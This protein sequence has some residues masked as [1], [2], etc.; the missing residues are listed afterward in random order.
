MSP[1]AST[2]CWQSP[3]RH[4]NHD[5]VESVRSRSQLEVVKRHLR[6][7]TLLLLA[8]VAGCSLSRGNGRPAADWNRQVDDVHRPQMERVRAAVAASNPTPL[9]FDGDAAM[10][11]LSAAF[12][13]LLNHHVDPL[14][15]T[16]LADAAIAG[17]ASEP[18]AQATAS[19][20]VDAAIAAMVTVHDPDGAY[21]KAE[22][23]AVAGDRAGSV[24]L[25]LTRRDGFLT[26]V[27]AIPDSP[28]ARA[29]IRPG[30]RLLAI[31]G[32]PAAAENLNAVVRT[33]RGPIGSG[34]TLTILRADSGREVNIT[35]TRER[36]L[37][38][39]VTHARLSPTHG[40]VRISLLGNDT[41][42]DLI[43]ALND[44]PPPSRL[45]GLVLDLRGNGG[46]LLS[47]SVAVADLF[48]EHGVI[49]HTVGRRP[50]DD[51]TIEARPGAIW[52]SVPL[53]VVVDRGTAAGG[54]IVAA[55]LQE[56]GRARLVGTETFGRDSIQT[57]IQLDDAAVLRLTTHRALTPNR[58]PLSHGVRPDV[59]FT[60][61]PPAAEP[62]PDDPAVAAALD[63]LRRE[64][65]EP[66]P[67]TQE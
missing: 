29:G 13:I 1:A 64:A 59:M 33:L 38:R 40:Y 58:S 51:E 37:L 26:V 3:Y 24:G 25:E 44:L 6:S 52:E 30:D 7:A 48:L 9:T 50:T 49:V 12:G 31:A 14:D 60:A 21:V 57:S 2:T 28:A 67:R 19:G 18:A 55:A 27:S 53:A 5:A 47:R 17:I 4:D 10:E 42:L 41:G 11:R 34:V 66:R 23:D 43:R 46:G 16:A 62:S 35:V 54:E 56:N 36:I 32:L 45:E 61:A 39:S 65:A 22:P 15:P 20:T 63:L 8:G